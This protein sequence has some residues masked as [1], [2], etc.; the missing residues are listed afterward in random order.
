MQQIPLWRRYVLTIEEA[1]N[2]FHIGE[3]KLRTIVDEHSYEDFYIMNGNRVLI[4]RERFEQFLDKASV[5]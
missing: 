1:A 3:A 5:I 2:Y 4:K